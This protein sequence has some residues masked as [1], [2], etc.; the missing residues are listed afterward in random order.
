MFRLFHV[1]MYPPVVPSN[2]PARGS[3]SCLLHDA[4]GFGIEIGSNDITHDPVSAAS[5]LRRSL[6]VVCAERN[7]TRPMP[8]T[9]SPGV[10]ANNPGENV[11]NVGR[12]TTAIIPRLSGDSLAKRHHVVHL[13]PND[14]TA[15]R[16]LT[17]SRGHDRRYPFAQEL[18]QSGCW[19]VY[20]S[21][22]RTSALG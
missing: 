5:A 17:E 4:R 15:Q 8:S 20:A 13:R 2:G 7:A 6:P 19:S 16:D 1:L 14:T 9:L 12:R 3:A 18:L 22:S 10:V 21:I 11:S